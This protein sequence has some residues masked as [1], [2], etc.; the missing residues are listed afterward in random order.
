[1]NIV[2]LT[3]GTEEWKAWRSTRF[4]AS[5]AP[6]MM[7]VCPYKSRDQ[8]LLEMKTGIEPKVDRNLQYIFD[9]GHRAE[10]KCRPIVED[11]I[12]QELFPVTG[13]R[14]LGRLNLGASFDGLSMNQNIVWECKLMNHNRRES[15]KSGLI[16]GFHHAQLA[17]QLLV[18]GAETGF[19]S[20]FDPDLIGD[21][22]HLMVPFGWQSLK[23]SAQDIIDGWEHFMDD[24]EAFDPESMTDADRSKEAEFALAENHYALA[25]SAFE[26]AKAE[27]DRAKDRLTAAAGG[28]NS[29][30]NNFRVY[31]QT[32][33]GQVSYA[34]ALKELAPD[35]D[36][37]PF[38]GKTTTSIQIKPLKREEAAA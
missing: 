7:G 10:A 22:A 3:Q 9:R 27:L 36:L 21:E 29:V 35:A 17:H 31:A 14:T 38:R 8:L 1:M 20:A 12:G 25:L 32:R 18:S 16:P 26:E 23:Y 28:K 19:F 6:A 24:L 11:I 33:R 5:N 2:E 34:K 30:G 4:T 13:E 15:L 37:E